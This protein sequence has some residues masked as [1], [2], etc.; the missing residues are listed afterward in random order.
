[1]T[2]RSVRLLSPHYLDLAMTNEQITDLLHFRHACKEFDLNKKI[3]QPD[4]DT[5]LEAARLSPSSFGIEPWKFLVVQNP[6]LREKI[7]VH[8]WGAQ[9]QLPT[10][11]HYVVVLARKS[12]FMAYD[13]PYVSQY[14]SEVQKS[15]ADVLER[16]L[17]IYENFQKVEFGIY[18]N[19]KAMF[20][21]SSKQTYIAL[22]NMM[23]VAALMGIDSCPVEGFHQE[24]L[25]ELLADSFGID[26]KQYGIS[27]MAAFGYKVNPIRPKVRLPES[28]VVQWFE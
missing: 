23:T 27:V 15:P 8:T 14:M 17:K 19:E 25:D 13:A 28:E 7:R 1:L 9:K 22:A 3:S 4:F 6:A 10:C 26:P 21:W 18:G 16:R 24:K 5:I 11:S 20:D 2:I 12:Y